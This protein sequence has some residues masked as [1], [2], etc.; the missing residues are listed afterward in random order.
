VS[1][2]LVLALAQI[3]LALVVVVAACLVVR[4]RV[5]T[6]RGGIVECCLRSSASGRWHHGLAEYRRAQLHWHRSFS[7]R[8]RPHGAFDRR[9]LVVTGSRLAGVR[10]PAWL[11]P[12]TMIVTCR[13][14]LAGLRPDRAG[15]PATWRLPVGQV[16][17]VRVIEL[18]M[19]QAALTGYM[20]WLEAAPAGYLSEAS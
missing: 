8:I 17:D 14:H 5:I 7:L 16:A 4:R 1:G 11:G 19:S 15:S 2:Q 10:D 18:A 6:R 12:G 13:A 20:A 9:D 3:A